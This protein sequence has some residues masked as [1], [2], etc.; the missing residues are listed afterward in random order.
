MTTPLRE[1]ERKWRGEVLP[2]PTGTSVEA[3]TARGLAKSYNCALISCADELAAALSAMGDGVRQVESTGEVMVCKVGDYGPVK[4]QM[5]TVLYD[6]MKV[7][8]C[9]TDEDAEFIGAAIRAYTSP[10]ASN[11]EAQG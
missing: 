9:Y 8:E 4:R 10:T 7:A 5:A 6:D 1:L 11:G 3:I 2:L